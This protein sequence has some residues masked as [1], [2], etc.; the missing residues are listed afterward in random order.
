[1][2]TG[3]V[4][5]S[6]ANERQST[7]SELRS[8]HSAAKRAKLPSTCTMRSPHGPRKCHAMASASAVRHF[9]NLRVGNGMDRSLAVGHGKLCGERRQSYITGFGTKATAGW[10][11]YPPTRHPTACRECEAVRLAHVAPQVPT[12]SLPTK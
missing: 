2:P 12:T 3:V 10:R 11:S 7:G 5:E 4:T 6:C 9:S 1:M 8:A